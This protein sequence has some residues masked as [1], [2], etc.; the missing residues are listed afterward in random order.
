MHHKDKKGH[1]TFLSFFFNL[2]HLYMV[3]PEDW[4]K[5]VNYF[6]L[7]CAVKLPQTNC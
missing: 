2:G 1:K 5:L 4:K 3:E 7:I 6:S